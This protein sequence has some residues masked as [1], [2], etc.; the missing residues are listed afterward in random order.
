M[1]TFEEKYEDVLMGIEMA[2][3]PVYRDS[4]DMSD[5]EAL[6][7]INALIRAYTARVRK[8]DEPTVNLSPLERQVYDAVK[9]LCEWRLGNP[10]YAPPDMAEYAEVKPLTTGEIIDCLKRIRR[11]IQLWQKE[12]G[13]RGYYEFASGFL[14]L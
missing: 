6:N 1:S 4:P 13:R 3:V 8:R 11:S 7:A 10:D 12:G 9:A 14:P 2:I 5:W